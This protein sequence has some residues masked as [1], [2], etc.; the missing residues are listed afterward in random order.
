MPRQFQIGRGSAAEVI[1][2]GDLAEQLRRAV[3]RLAP[4]VTA[5]IETEAMKLEAHAQERWPVG[6][7]KTEAGKRYTKR[8]REAGK[9]VRPHSKALFDYG[10]RVL[11]DGVEGFVSNR[12]PYWYKIKTKQGGLGGKSASVE[13]L[14]KPLKKR[15]PEI[16]KDLADEVKALV[17]EG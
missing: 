3:Y 15:I 16:A 5:R 13:L 2:S 4:T 17:R 1:G 9:A 11:S 10:L 14:R 12:A 8:D 7:D 6:R